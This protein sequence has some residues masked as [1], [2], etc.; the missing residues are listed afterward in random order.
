MIYT[1][2]IMKKLIT[3]SILSIQRIR[4]GSSNFVRSWKAIVDFVQEIKE[5]SVKFS[6]KCPQNFL[7]EEAAV[8]QFLL[9]IA[10]V[11]HCLYIEMQ[12]DR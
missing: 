12:T 5:L 4:T 11:Q 8:M 2:E 7:H 9:L 1:D 6:A 3:Q 10:W